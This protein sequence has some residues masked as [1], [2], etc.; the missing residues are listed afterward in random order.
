[1]ADIEFAKSYTLT[2]VI[3]PKETVDTVWNT[4]LCSCGSRHIDESLDNLGKATIS[5]TTELSPKISHNQVSVAIYGNKNQYVVLNPGEKVTVNA[6]TDEAAQ[7]Y[8]AQAVAGVLEV[9]NA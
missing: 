8:L 5:D 1:M 7:F 4:G 9:K 2:N 6:D 3:A